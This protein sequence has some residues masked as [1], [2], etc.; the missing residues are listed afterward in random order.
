MKIF[1][2]LEDFMFAKDS[3][4]FDTKKPSNIKYW[5]SKMAGLSEPNMNWVSTLEEKFFHSI[6]RGSVLSIFHIITNETSH[7]NKEPRT[8][9]FKS[10]TYSICSSI[11]TDA[12]KGLRTGVYQ[13]SQEITTKLRWYIFEAAKIEEEYKRNLLNN[14]E[15]KQAIEAAEILNICNYF[16]S[17]SLKWSLMLVY[18]QI[19]IIDNIIITDW[20]ED[21]F[22]K[23]M[24]TEKY[25]KQIFN[26]MIDYTLNN[27]KE[28]S[29][30]IQDLY[31]SLKNMYINSYM[32]NELSTLNDYQI[33]KNLA[34]IENWIL[35]ILIMRDLLEEPLKYSLSQAIEQEDVILYEVYESIKGELYRCDLTTDAIFLIQDK[36]N[37]LKTILEI[38]SDEND[39]FKIDS[40]PRKLL[41][42]LELELQTLISNPQI[43]I[44]ALYESK[45]KPIETN[46]SVPELALLFRILVD[47]KVVIVKG[48]KVDLFRSVTKVFQSK[49]TSSISEDSFK[50]KY[51]SPENSAIEFWDEKFNDFRDIVV[52]YKN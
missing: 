35:I 20:K 10:K 49:S 41:E 34:R 45:I 46:L 29:G 23:S 31:I 48:T 27:L 8:E 1:E 44:R 22:L 9:Y 13:S 50:N 40:V 6:Y 16:T 37:T 43:D 12:S 38:K 21:S 19:S 2:Q 14:Y 51:N 11:L 15:K 4:Y 33:K 42:K 36:I 28:D 30:H 39:I 24:L 47:E 7:L 32:S 18:R 17:I 5:K 25:D 3:F 26:V 52:D